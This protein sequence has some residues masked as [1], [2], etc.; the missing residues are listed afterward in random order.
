MK[1]TP[2]ANMAQSR[3]TS[4]GGNL[5]LNTESVSSVPSR[6]VG[7][8]G[9]AETP[10]TAASKTGTRMLPVMTVAPAGSSLGASRAPVEPLT[11]DFFWSLV[12]EN[13]EKVTKKID[14]MA[15]DLA[16][17][18]RSVEQNKGEIK[19]N[20]EETKRHADLIMEQR[21]LLERLG[22]RVGRLEAGHLDGTAPAPTTSN[23]SQE[24]LRARLSIWFRPV[25]NASEDS[26]WKG[27][28]EF[29]HSALKIREADMSPDDIESVRALPDPATPLGNLNS[30]ALLTF[31]SQ[32]K[33]DA[34]MSKVSNLATFDDAAGKP[35]RESASRCLQNWMIRSGCCPGL[36]PASGRGTVQGLK[37]T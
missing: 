6:A 36:G 14:A 29:I 20:T 32:K 12:G 13:T 24:Y 8:D 2:Q 26:L 10:D 35:T 33:R 11:A 16:A 1:R 15:A 3:L 25:N 22:E 19:K 31:C 27:V 28:G 18:T 21:T 4:S 17:L 9:V 37:G 7:T 30:E 34:V 5:R 23:K